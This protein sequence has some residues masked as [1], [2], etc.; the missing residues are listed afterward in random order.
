MKTQPTSGCWLWFSSTWQSKL[1]HHHPDTW[2][3]HQRI[4]V[5]LSS[6][7]HGVARTK[8]VLETSYIAF[9]WH[10]AQLPPKLAQRCWAMQA[11]TRTL[12]NTKVG[13]IKHDTHTK[14]S[15]NN[16]VPPTI[17]SMNYGSLTTS[18]V[19]WV[20]ARNMCRIGLSCW[21]LDGADR[22]RFIEG[23]GVGAWG[24][25]ISTITEACTIPRHRLSTIMI[26]PIPHP[27]FCAPPNH[28]VHPTFVVSCFGKKRKCVQYE[29]LYYVFRFLCKVDYESD[30][31]IHAPTYTYNEVITVLEL[32]CV[33]ECE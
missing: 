5:S 16:P 26:L 20:V 7:E 17:W 23:G 27:H 2:A 6:L 14:S 9:K 8:F 29:H 4:E 13:T 33:V 1:L 32:A 21:A 30:K 28:D 12:C 10:I 11:I 22:N 31:F 18:S 19:V 3:T 24:H 15:R 25:R